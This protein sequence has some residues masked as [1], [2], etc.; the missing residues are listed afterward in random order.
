M[1]M[2]EAAAEIKVAG[3]SRPSKYRIEFSGPQ[4]ILP[5][6]ANRRLSINCEELSFPGRSVS[7]QEV[8]YHGPLRKMPY[9]PTF[10]STMSMTFRVGGDFYEKKLFERWL[11]KIANPVTHDMGYYE[12]Y[13]QTLTVY[14][15]ENLGQFDSDGER[16]EVEV[17]EERYIWAAVIEEVFPEAIQDMAL[18]HGSTDQYNRITVDFAFRKYTDIP[19]SASADSETVVWRQQ[20]AQ[21]SA[22]SSGTLARGIDGKIIDTF[23]RGSAVFGTSRRFIPGSGRGQFIP[24]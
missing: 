20:D 23:N 16:V 4:D 18:G 6:L 7:T 19:Y 13:A 1:S 17:G 5:T 9:T 21:D 2:R 11:D 10:T 3:L 8:R 24:F 14:Q 22:G 12:D 15:L